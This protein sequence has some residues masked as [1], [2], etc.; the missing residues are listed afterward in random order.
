MWV[1]GPLGLLG[2]QEA[3]LQSLWALVVG[4][5]EGGSRVILPAGSAG[6]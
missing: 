3:L 2:P 4:D 5:G 6:E 1:I